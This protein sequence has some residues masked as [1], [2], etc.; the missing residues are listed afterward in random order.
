MGPTGRMMG[1]GGIQAMPKP[2]VGPTTMQRN[3]SMVIG[4]VQN[5]QTPKPIQE[6]EE[7]QE[8]KKPEHVK[9]NNDSSI[10]IDKDPFGG[11]SKPTDQQGKK[12]AAKDAFGFDIDDDDPFGGK[13]QK[14]KPKAAKDDPFGNDDPFAGAG[15]NKNQEK[16]SKKNDADDIF[17]QLALEDE[18]NKN[19]RKL[20][21]G[22]EAGEKKKTEDDPFGVSLSAEILILIPQDD[23]KQKKAESDSFEF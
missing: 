12:P 11:P 17:A 3:N 2:V 23:K 8:T 5:G 21:F 14:N 7:I 18:K 4:G 10:K 16:E 1:P 20:N 6:I 15:G 19:K 22:G 9:P 13:N